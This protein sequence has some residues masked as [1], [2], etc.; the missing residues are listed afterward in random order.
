MLYSFGQGLKNIWRN[1]M[2][3]LASIATMSACIFLFGLIFIILINVQVMVQEAE[4]SVTITVFFDEGTSDERIEEI[5]EEI[6]AQDGVIGIKFASAEQALEEYIEEYMAGN[7]E[8]AEGLAEDNPLVD[9]ANYEVYMK[10]ISAQADLASYIESIENVRQVN[11]SVIAANILTDF[12]RLLAYASIVIMAILLGVAVFLISNTIRVGISVRADEIAIMKLIG[13]GNLFV[14]A[15]FMIEGVVIGLLGSVIP[16]ILLYFLYQRIIAYIMTNFS[17]LA[18]IMSFLP[19]G[20]V[21]LYLVPIA[22]ILGAG[23]G[24]LG[25]AL[26]C[27]KHLKV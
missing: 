7:E 15:P 3:S 24:L 11:Q 19:A 23:I 2:F 18:D 12:N 16:L 27:R 13:A 8:A 26:T 21:F 4:Q 25:S 17:F 10:D 9:S 14:R 1:K 5:G 6:L 20:K 22:L